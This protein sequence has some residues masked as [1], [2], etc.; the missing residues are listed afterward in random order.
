[1]RA[2]VRGGAKWPKRAPTR[3]QRSGPRHGSAGDDGA[4]R[5]GSCAGPG[6]TSS[7]D[8]RCRAGRRGGSRAGANGHGAG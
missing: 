7:E 5:I 8:G 3:P 2:Q 4:L 6:G 1:M